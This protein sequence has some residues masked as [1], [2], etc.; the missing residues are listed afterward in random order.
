MICSSL[1]PKCEDESNVVLEDESELGTGA[2]DYAVRGGGE[3]FGFTECLL[4]VLSDLI[5]Q[6]YIL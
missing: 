1:V 5:V 6:M 3:R 2:V 4:V